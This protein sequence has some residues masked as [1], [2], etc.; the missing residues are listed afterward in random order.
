MKKHLVFNVYWKPNQVSFFVDL[1]SLWQSCGIRITTLRTIRNDFILSATHYPVLMIWKLLHFGGCTSPGISK[2]ILKEGSSTGKVFY[3][4]DKIPP[5]K[6]PEYAYKA[7]DYIQA[8]KQRRSIIGGISQCY[9]FV[10]ARIAS[11]DECS[12]KVDKKT[13]YGKQKYKVCPWSVSVSNES[14]MHQRLF[15]VP[16]KVIITFGN[17]SGSATMQLFC[18]QLQVDQ[19]A[20]SAAFTQQRNYSHW[21]WYSFIACMIFS[22]K[23][24]NKNGYPLSFWSLRLA[25][26]TSGCVGRTLIFPGPSTFGDV[27]AAR[28]PS[29]KLPAAA[30]PKLLKR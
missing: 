13:Y 2:N 19:E 21:I 6:A 22:C 7:L 5:K 28:G 8:G 24:M 20:P 9:I 23:S 1:T 18:C 4:M 27:C 11:V 26:G 30:H 10:R 16:T 29:V 14:S 12:V 25:R 15:G 17:R 3:Y